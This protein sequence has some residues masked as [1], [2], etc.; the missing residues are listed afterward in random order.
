M[1]H[2]CYRGENTVLK[3]F[4]SGF[5]S[6]TPAMISFQLLA[7]KTMDKY[8]CAVTQWYG[9][10][11]YNLTKVHIALLVGQESKDVLSTV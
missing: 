3:C 9:H 10:A 2:L 8:L 4:V 5:T 6:M 7:G 1:F 11:N